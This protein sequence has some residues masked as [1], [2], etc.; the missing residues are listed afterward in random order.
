MTK[1]EEQ[2]FQ[3]FDE[4][5]DKFHYFFEDFDFEEEW[6]R[7]L[8]ARQRNDIIEMNSIM[9]MV[10]YELPDTKFNIINDPPGWSDF[11]WLLEEYL[12]M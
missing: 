3:R 12:D 2:W 9:N 10:W 8:A 1:R 11:L 5:K 6:R 7:L 4:T